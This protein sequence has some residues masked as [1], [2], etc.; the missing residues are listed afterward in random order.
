MIRMDV[1]YKQHLELLYRVEQDDIPNEDNI[2]QMRSGPRW[3]K[4]SFEHLK[5]TSFKIFVIV[6]NQCLEND[7]F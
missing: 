7:S 4:K 5:G 6:G 1:K 3:A 2:E